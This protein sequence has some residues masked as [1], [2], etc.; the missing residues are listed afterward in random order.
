MPRQTLKLPPLA[1]L[2]CLFLAILGWALVTFSKDYQVTYQF[3]LQCYN[4]PEGKK[5]VTASDSVLSMT[6]NQKGLKYLIA[7]FNKKDKVVYL[8]MKD[9]IQPK[10]KVSVYTFT[11]KEIR[12]FL[13]KT[14][15]GS[16]LV[17]VESPEVITFYVR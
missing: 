7:P 8:S 2:V 13:S 12:D 4:Y 5:S 15:F 10:H 16:E 14:L 3:K 6:F 9:L 1:F 11:N 17:T